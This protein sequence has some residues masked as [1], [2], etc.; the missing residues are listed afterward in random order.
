MRLLI[1]HVYRQGWMKWRLNKVNVDTFVSKWY[2]WVCLYIYIY[3]Y[4][5]MCVCVFIYLHVCLYIYI[6]RELL[7]RNMAVFL[8]MRKTTNFLSFPRLSTNIQ[9]EILQNQRYTYAGCQVAMMSKFCTVGPNICGS[10]VWILLH[11]TILVPGNVNCLLD[12]LNI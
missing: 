5:Y 11:G 9:N 1:L 12:F 10:S 7:Q 2:R 6:E 4:I 3:I 8:T